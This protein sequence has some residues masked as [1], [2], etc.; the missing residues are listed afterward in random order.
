MDGVIEVV[1]AAI[2]RDGRVLAARKAAG[3][4]AGFW[5]FPGGK[6]EPGEAPSEALRREILEELGCSIAVGAVVAATQHRYP[7]AH[8]RL[9]TRLCQL[10]A[11]NPTARVHAELRWLDIN[12]IAGTRWAPADV[13]A[14]AM[15]GGLLLRP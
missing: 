12:E 2:I 11:G 10:V 8:I 13:E 9:T 1:A 5:E 3:P 15:L 4:L 6:V 14:A 7:F